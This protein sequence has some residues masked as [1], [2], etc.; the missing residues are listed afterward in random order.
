MRSYLATLL[1]YSS[2]RDY[3]VAGIVLVVL[4]IVGVQSFMGF[5]DSI[6]QNVRVETAQIQQRPEPATRNYSVV[7]SVLDDT[8]ATGSIGGQ[9]N[10]PVV[11]DPCTGQVKSK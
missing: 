1:G 2:T 6:R 10:R 8:V 9:G 4:S 11:L 5:V 3:A 7:R